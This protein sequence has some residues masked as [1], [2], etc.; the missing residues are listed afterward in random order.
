MA[1]PIVYKPLKGDKV[2]A[3]KKLLKERA[4]EAKARATARANA[5]V[6]NR[7]CYQHTAFKDWKPGDKLPHCTR[8][9]ARLDPNENHVC[10]VKLGTEE[11]KPKYK[12]HTE[13]TKERWE[14]QREEI[15]KTRRSML[16]APPKCSVCGEELEDFEA[17]E[18]HFEDHG[19]KPEKEHYARDGEPDGDLDGYDDEPE[20]DYC[21]GDDDGYDCD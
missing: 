4:D 1:L 19:G 11:F 2:E 15:R 20:E 3:A 16:I 14:A 13:E 10:P 5:P 21:E 18:W 6:P 7:I 8:C 17:G 9:E 12:E